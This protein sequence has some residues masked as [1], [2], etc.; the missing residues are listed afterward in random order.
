MVTV[1]P[2]NPFDAKP[3]PPRPEHTA[4][5][6]EF[7]LGVDLGETHD[8]TAVVLLERGGAD[9]ETIHVRGINVLPLNLDYPTQATLLSEMIN[10]PIKSDGRSL[11]GRC[12]MAVDATAVGTPVVQFMRPLINCPTIPVLITSG[13]NASRDERGWYKVP[14]RDLIGIAQVALEHRVLDFAGDLPN[15]DRLTSE[16]GAYRVKVSTDGHDSYGN[17]ARENPHD[18]VVLALAI[19]VW[20]A[21]RNGWGRPYPLHLNRPN[22]NLDLDRAALEASTMLTEWSAERPVIQERASRRPPGNRDPLAGWW[23]Q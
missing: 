20:A 17:S 23:K 2:H 19:G 14:K 6:R 15:L 7:I 11:V 21:Y 13:T 18:D 9:G 8:H 22:R 3:L 4:H 1:D 10:R 16:L 5:H 12:N